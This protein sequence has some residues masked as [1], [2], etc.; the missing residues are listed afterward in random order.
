MV[1]EME[2]AAGGGGGGGGERKERERDREGG[3]EELLNKRGPSSE[4]W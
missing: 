4:G 2:V 1:R 3:R